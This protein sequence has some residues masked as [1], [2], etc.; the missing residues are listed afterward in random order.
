MKIPGQL[1]EQG[2][3]PSPEETRSI[4]KKRARAL[5]RE[6]EKTETTKEFLEIVEFGLSQET[7]GY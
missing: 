2:A 1:L 7:Y 3:R 5:A 6:P 4:L